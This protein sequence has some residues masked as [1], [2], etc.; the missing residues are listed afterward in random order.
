MAPEAKLTEKEIIEHWYNNWS[1]A[2]KPFLKVIVDNYETCLKE[3][4][5]KRMACFAKVVHEKKVEL[6]SSVD[7]IL[8]R[9]K[10]L[11]GLK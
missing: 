9:V 4:G 6:V 8:A 11:A 3:T 1:T 10:E 5:L 7:E 2:V